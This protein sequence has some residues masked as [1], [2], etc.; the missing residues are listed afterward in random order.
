MNCDHNFISIRGNA[1]YCEEC[2]LYLPKYPEDAKKER[3]KL[4]R[5]AIKTIGS[6][7]PVLSGIFQFT[8][9]WEEQ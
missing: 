1:L 6:T 3:E 2:C 9:R 8:F 4:L 5:D 7:A